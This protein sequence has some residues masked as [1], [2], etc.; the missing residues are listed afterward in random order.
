MLKATKRTISP[1]L[2]ASMMLAQ[3]GK[4]ACCNKKFSANGKRESGAFVDYAGKTSRARSLLC[5]RCSRAVKQVRESS[6]HA[7]L[8]SAYLKQWNC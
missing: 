7:H 2:R 5:N 4:C 1:G 8:L 3:N 6:A